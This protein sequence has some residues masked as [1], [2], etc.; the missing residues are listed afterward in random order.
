[1]PPRTGR[2]PKKKR[3]ITGLKNQPSLSTITMLAPP[4]RC[5]SS[6][7]GSVE[8]DQQKRDAKDRASSEWEDD[9]ETDFESDGEW[10]G[11]MD[12]KFGQNLAAL[13]Y[14]EDQTDTDWIPYRLRQKTKI[15]KGMKINTSLR[16]VGSLT[17]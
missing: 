9:G 4:D 2:P 12:K 14:K 8:H 13:A 10:V 11:H 6:P 17:T 3:N 1:M 7:D 15:K 5:D 16:M